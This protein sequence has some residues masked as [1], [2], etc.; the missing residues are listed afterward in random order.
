[1]DHGALYGKSMI[2]NEI[3]SILNENAYLHQN[4]FGLAFLQNSTLN[5]DQ[6]RSLGDTT[7]LSSKQPYS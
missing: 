2:P 1:M 6:P 7:A 4:N 5:S 3:M